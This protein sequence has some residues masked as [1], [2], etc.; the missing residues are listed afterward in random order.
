MKG[1]Q[2]LCLRGYALPTIYFYD[3]WLP[4]QTSVAMNMMLIFFLIVFVTCFIGSTHAFFTLGSM[5]FL[6]NEW[7]E[8]S[9]YCVIMI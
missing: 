7:A 5:N 1:L 6:L 3:V 2:L 8:T 9:K 4:N